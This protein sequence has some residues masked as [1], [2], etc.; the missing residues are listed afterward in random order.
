MF[1]YSNYLNLKGELAKDK[2][3][4]LKRIDIGIKNPNVRRP[5]YL[6]GL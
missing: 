3:E 6:R 1:E 2:K 5:D 4:F